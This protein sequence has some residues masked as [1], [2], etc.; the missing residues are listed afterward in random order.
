[1]VRA[2]PSSLGSGYFASPRATIYSCSY[3]SQA[4]RNLALSERALAD[5][6]GW[7]QSAQFA[8]ANVHQFTN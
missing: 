3:S 4:E 5:L 6:A 7:M 1:M 2:R 8:D